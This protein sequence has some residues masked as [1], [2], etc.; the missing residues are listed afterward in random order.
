MDDLAGPD[1]LAMSKTREQLG[2]LFCSYGY[3]PVDVVNKVIESRGG[4]KTL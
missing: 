2:S 1:W 4:I 3:V